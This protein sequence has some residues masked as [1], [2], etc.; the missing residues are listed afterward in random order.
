M[1]IIPESQWK[2]QLEVS[3][4]NQILLV[5]LLTQTRI[6]QDTDHHAE[7]KNK[8][9]KTIN[10]QETLSTFGHGSHIPKVVYAE[11]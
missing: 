1:N 11:Q 9:K 7:K 4:S 8:K 3:W 2:G 10:N 6:L 5:M